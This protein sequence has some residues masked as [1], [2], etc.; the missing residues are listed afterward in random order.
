M[1]APRF[2][3]LV[4]SLSD[5][6]LRRDALRALAGGSVIL[7]AGVMDDEAEARKKKKKKRC[8]KLG[9]ACGG[10]KKCCQGDGTA[11]CQ[12]FNNPQCQGVGLLGNVCC[13]TEGTLCDPTFG[14]PLA[15][16]DPG[17]RGNCSCCADLFCGEQTDGSFRC[18][19]EFT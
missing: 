10:R 6:L 4:R 18:Q 7:A 3:R 1:D 11:L 8:R 5:R 17:S 16:M 13:G 9:S 2:D 12:A 19:T 14:T 15:P